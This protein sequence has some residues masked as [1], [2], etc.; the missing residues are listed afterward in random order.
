MHLRGLEL[1]SNGWDSTSAA[2]LA[3]LCLWRL[4]IAKTITLKTTAMAMAAPDTAAILRIPK[5]WEPNK[6]V[7]EDV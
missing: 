5:D 3:T 1:Y 6:A 2:S 4:Q 7:G